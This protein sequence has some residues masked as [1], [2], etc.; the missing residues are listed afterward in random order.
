MCWARCALECWP[1]RAGQAQ[2]CS[3]SRVTIFEIDAEVRA[4]LSEIGNDAWYI[5]KRVAVFYTPRADARSLATPN[6]LFAE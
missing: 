2:G 3:I 4:V 1:C 5:M 6:R